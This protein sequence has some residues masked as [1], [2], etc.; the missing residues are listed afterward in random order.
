[1]GLIDRFDLGIMQRVDVGGKKLHNKKWRRAILSLDVNVRWLR[2]VQLGEQPEEG[3]QS[4]D[5]LAYPTPD[6]QGVCGHL[7]HELSHLWLVSKPYLGI[8]ISRCYLGPKLQAQH[9]S[10]VARAKISSMR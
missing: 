2:K 6:K 3:G 5:I 4:W 10:P 7:S 9:S 8:S 1:M